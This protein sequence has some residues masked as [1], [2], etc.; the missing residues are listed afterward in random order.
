MR[1]RNPSL[2]LVEFW[3]RLVNRGYKRHIVSLYRI[4]KRMN[5]IERPRKKPYIPKPYKQMTYPGERVQIDCKF[6]PKSCCPNLLAGERYYQFTAIDEF[7]RLR[8]LMGFK[9]NSTYSAAV[10]LQAAVDFYAKFDIQ[11]NTVQTDNGFEFT[12]RFSNSKK[13]KPTLFQITAASFGI[14][15]KTIKPFTPR[16]NGK[17]ERS[18]REDQKRFYNS[19]SFY[20]FQDYLNQLK[21]YLRRSNKIP[22]RPLKYNSPITFLALHS[23][24]LV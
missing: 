17:V 11:V 7:S 1:R 16:H 8:F 15:H 4:M 12:N 6:V 18:H 19:R 13:D 23:V 2:G 20:S 5:L 14:Q 9:D 10:F 24:Q 3:F 22:M 21:V